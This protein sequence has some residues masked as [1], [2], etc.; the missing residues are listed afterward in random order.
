[1]RNGLLITVGIVCLI[2]AGAL[3]AYIASSMS[4]P[5][6]QSVQTQPSGAGVVGTGQNDADAFDVEIRFTNEGFS[7][8]DITI[9]RGTRVRFYNASDDEFWP[10][11]GIHPTH[12]LY[13]EKQPDDCL[14]STFDS[15]DA[16]KPGQFYDYTFYYEGRWPYHDHLRAFNSGSITVE[17]ATSTAQ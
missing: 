6:P 3:S 14:G 1:M 9:P 4:R 12:T 13:P 11:S 7:P 10:A 15:C 5:T 16:L 8:R 17:S 2:F